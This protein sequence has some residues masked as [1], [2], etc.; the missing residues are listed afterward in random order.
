MS[1]E[2]LA[3]W[4][5][6]AN[7]Q[8]ITGARNT[9]AQEAAAAA[10]ATG[11][12]ATGATATAAATE[13]ATVEEELQLPSRGPR[14][15]KHTLQFKRPPESRELAT[16][17]LASFE[18]KFPEERNIRGVNVHSQSICDRDFPALAARLNNY[19][20][21]DNISVEDKYNRIEGQLR[22]CIAKRILTHKGSLRNKY[23]SLISD[24][25]HLGHILQLYDMYK[26]FEQRYAAGTFDEVS[27]IEWIVTTSRLGQDGYFQVT[28]TSTMAPLSAPPI[29]VVQGNNAWGG[30]RKT[31]KARKSK[32]KQTRRRR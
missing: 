31:R 29:S 17:N 18:S 2:P 23:R 13:V 30:K 12:T 27:K 28:Y 22:R 3:N 26:N 25:K 15:I 16:T 6:M 19:I 1:K 20:N 9:A 8:G 11:A 32:R 10:T 5:T 24:K 14:Q 7:E 4:E 21:V